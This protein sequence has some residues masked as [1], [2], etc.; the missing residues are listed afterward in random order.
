VIHGC[1]ALC[2]GQE[3]AAAFSSDDFVGRSQREP[4]ES[5]RIL[6]SAVA[7]SDTIGK[8]VRIKSNPKPASS[9]K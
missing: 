5:Y 7:N 2:F 1:A 8:T 9:G 6:S 4:E 3:A